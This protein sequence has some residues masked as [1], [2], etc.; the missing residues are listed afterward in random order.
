MHLAKY[1]AVRELIFG[2][3]SPF[4]F[5]D[6]V[7]VAKKHGCDDREIVIAVLADLCS[8]GMLIIRNNLFYGI[9]YK[10]EI[11]PAV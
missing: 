5:E 7:K 3:P 10:A 6:V 8:S 1:N 11:K 4:S 2:M 9:S